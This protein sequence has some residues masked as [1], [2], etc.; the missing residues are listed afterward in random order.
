MER[1]GKDI[2]EDTG[3]REHCGES[4]SHESALQI[5]EE[6]FTQC[7]GRKAHKYLPRFR[8]FSA[9]GADRFAMTWHWP[10]FFVTFWWMLYRKLYLWALVALN[11]RG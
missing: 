10:A 5:T 1:P 7:L 8:K 6:D 2:S 4:L 11:Q 3:S 9:R